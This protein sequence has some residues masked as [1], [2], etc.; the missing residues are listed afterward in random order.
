MDATTS[1][2]KRRRGALFSGGFAHFIHDGFTDCLFVLLPLWASGFGL[3]HAQVGFLKMCMS[4]SMSVMQVP[5][6]LLA[7]RF[8]ERAVLTAGTLLVGGGFALVSMAD[9]FMLLAVTLILAGTGCAVQHPLASSIVSTEHEGG[10]RRAA[11]GMYNFAGDLGK[12]AVPFTVAAIIGVYGWRTGA[13]SYGILGI[14]AGIA[15]FIALTRLGLGRRREHHKPDAVDAPPPIKGWGLRD[16]QGFGVLSTISMIDSAA[17]M[18]FMT[19][20]PFLLMAKGLDITGMGFALALLFAGGAAGKLI[21]GLVAERLGILRTV[22]LT[23]VATALLIFA[24]IALPLTPALVLLPLVGIAL[25]GTSSV[26]YG[27]VGDFVVPERQAR[28]FGLFYTFG[29]AAGAVAPLVFGIVSDAGGLTMALSILAA[30][31][32]LTLPL[33]LMLRPSLAAV[34][35]T[36]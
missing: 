8:G 3:S 19:F 31:V 5:A 12:V 18:G 22:V 27:T 30:M 4:G 21:C 15:I 17:R 26:L 9:G 13:V 33:C 32:A 36:A 11:L 28:G 23:E 25:N 16:P 20:L 29:T 6:G 10:S 1:I 34:S 2:R 35:R 14:F 7:E 24:L